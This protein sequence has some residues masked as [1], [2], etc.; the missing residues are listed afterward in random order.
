MAKVDSAKPFRH[1]QCV[2]VRTSLQG[3]EP[4]SVLEAVGFDD[5]RIAV[6][7]ADRVS[8]PR[9]LDDLGQRTSI[10]EHLTERHTDERF[11]QERGDLRRVENAKRPASKLIRGVPGGRQ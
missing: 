11:V 1:A 4:A 9:G 2:A 8:E 7:P 10:G 6:P 5:K 3:I